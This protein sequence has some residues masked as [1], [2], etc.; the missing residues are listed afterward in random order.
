M[1]YCSNEK[2][3]RNC[4]CRSA[5]N[6]TA[7][8]NTSN[9]DAR[10]SLSNWGVAGRASSTITKPGGGPALSI[11]SVKLLYRDSKFL[12]AD[13]GSKKADT[14]VSSTAAFVCAAAQDVY[15]KCC[16]SRPASS[17]RSATRNARIDCTILGRTVLKRL[18]AVSSNDKGEQS[19][20][21][22]L[23]AFRAAALVGPKHFFSKFP[24]FQFPCTFTSW[25]FAAP[26][27][28]GW[29]RLRA[30]LAIMSRDV[31]RPFIRR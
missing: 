13:W 16:L 11:S 21:A 10:A 17:A 8:R 22:I 24:A 4:T 31:T 18:V 5:Q 30:R 28:A 9:R 25:V 26:L 6:S 19:V 7:S 2:K 1:A 12:P 23:Q 20:C 27:W 3:A 14:M 15:K 29:R